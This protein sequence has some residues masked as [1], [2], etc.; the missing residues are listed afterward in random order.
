MPRKLIL[1]NYL[2]PGDIIMLTAAV[3]DLMLTYPNE[4]L[5]KVR[6]SC[7]AL[8]DFCETLL[9]ETLT[10]LCVFIFDSECLGV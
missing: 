9:T 2:S 3:R 4:F 7:D 8:F 5:V 10:K 6:T 1:E